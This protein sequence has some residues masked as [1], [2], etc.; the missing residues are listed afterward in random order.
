MKGQQHNGI[1]KHPSKDKNHLHPK[2]YVKADIRASGGSESEL[3]FYRGAYFAISI[4][5]IDLKFQRHTSL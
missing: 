3:Q 1:S 2:M 4:T 5:Y